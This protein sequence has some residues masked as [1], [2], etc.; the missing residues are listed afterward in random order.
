M[1]ALT[2]VLKE[3]VDLDRVAS[4]LHE[5]NKPRVSISGCVDS[6]KVHMIEA[7][8][9][10]YKNRIIAT[11][12]DAKAREIV[13][14]L[15]LYEKNVYLYPAKDLIF[16]Q[17]DIHNN[18]LVSE[19]LKVIRRVAQGKPVTIVTT[20]DALLA[21]Q[22]PIDIY[23]KNT[24]ILNKGDIVSE[25][26]IA[27][28][29]VNMGYVRNYQV[30]NPGEFSMRGGIIDIF[31]AT[32]D[33]PVRIELWGDDI[34]SVRIFD[35]DSQ[36]SIQML[37]GVEI[38][39]ASEIVLSEDDLEAGLERIGEESESVASTF[40]KQ[41]LTEEGYRVSSSFK[42]LKEDLT[43]L[44]RLTNLDGYIDYFYENTQRLTDYFDAGNTVLF[45]D[46]PGRLKEHMDF[47]LAE[48]RDSCE[49]RLSKGYMLP[50]QAGLLCDRDELMGSC[51]L[52]I[53]QISTLEDRGVLTK[54]SLKTSIDARQVSP[55]RGAISMLIGDLKTYRKK[56]YRILLVSSSG[57]RAQRLAGDLRDDD[58]PAIYTQDMS[59]KLIPGEVTCIR[60]H[61][62]KGYEYTTLKLVVISE[63]DIFG[64]RERKKRSRKRTGGM[65]M[66]E[67][68]Q[69]KVGDYV[70]HEN[71]GMGVYRG[72]EKLEIEKVTKDYLKVE[73]ADGGLVYILPANLDILQKYASADI[74][75]KP[76]LNK[77]GGK[78]WTNTKKR[79]REAV[80]VVADDLVKLYAARQ[81]R[82]GFQ[83]G[84]DTVWQREFEEL[85][86]F[87][88]TEDQLT[89]VA[90][91]KR[92]MESSRIMDRLICGDV[93]YG[94][95]EIALRAAF[96]A[97]SE[98]KQV[99]VLVP[100][101]ILASQHYTTF[102][103]RM[104][105]FP[106]KIEVLSRFKTPSQQKAVL[107]ELSK[108]M[109][110]IIIG[111][112]RLLSS[113]VV[114]KDL[115]LL[116][117]DE[118]QRFGVTHKEKIKKLKE[119]VDVLTLSATPIPR[120]LHMSLVGIRDMSVLEEPPGERLPIQTFVCEYNEEMVREAISRELSRGGQV[121]YVY[122]KISSIAEVTAA[123]SALVP[124]A[125][126]EYAHG[127]MK[128]SE[129][130]RIMTDFV[131]GSIDVLVS[132][133]IIETGLDISN[134]NTIIIHDS[135]KMGLSQLYQ[136][137]GRVGRSSRTAYAFLLYRRDKMLKEVAEKRL[138]A[139]REYTDLG[140]GFKIAMRDLE[141]RGAGNILGRRQHGHMEAVGY[142]LYCKMLNEAVMRRKGIDV[143]D[144]DF[145]TQIDLDINA[146]IPGDY[147]VNEIQKLDIY[148]R[149]ASLQTDREIDDCA[150]E[151]RDRFGSLPEVASNLLEVTRLR[152][153][154]HALQATSIKG[155]QG[156]ITITMKPDANLRVEGIP[157]VMLKMGKNLRF[158]SRGTPAFI[159]RYEL[160]KIATVDAQTLLQATREL[161]DCMETE[162]LQSL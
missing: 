120:T 56:G 110:D 59:R 141:I 12:S 90:D 89:A 107:S 128:E 37:E 49:G 149:I 96:K 31:D 80:D 114:Y 160:T 64:V 22:V 156:E 105:N 112:H 35:T 99:A 23:R 87:E 159:Y 129:L 133:T 41:F 125:N 153:R 40:R 50:G 73:Y 17:A 113:D 111:T 4:T 140:S 154:A 34:E 26:D 103:Q 123:I 85:F 9:D 135:D 6:Q 27:Q 61:L 102:T 124:D 71:F 42:T 134:V 147:I 95:T 152:N 3:W 65:T 8:G 62:S 30:E 32:E 98:G 29:L 7:V 74:E 84:P 43:E 132:T 33:N 145:N 92:D 148:K 39:P 11:F 2:E 54:S 109:V 16:Y 53:V 28:K 77:L 104:K 19:R 52:P 48:Y 131:E 146:Y 55:Y 157:D 79:V 137:R 151:L 44:G 51:K 24:L 118:E 15:L 121:Y 13:S 115:G 81:S 47:V 45:L 136:L 57:S 150:D 72:I 58:M 76:K 1:N 86:P 67:F 130:E 116:V 18:K 83:Y 46:E 143:E 161:I 94:K 78:E 100:T 75:K 91:T 82:P 10:D 158:I 38:F 5:T 93:G 139:I 63:G 119:D 60:G 155:G 68:G 25:S 108:G 138:E 144:Q 20:A 14:D 21:K 122:N 142:D 126:V 69:L 106:I 101:T 70:V 117:V 66:K 127:R 36:R 97:V 162:L 88:E